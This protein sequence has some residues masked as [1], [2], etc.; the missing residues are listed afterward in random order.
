MSDQPNIILIITDQQRYDT[1]NALGA[2]W[3]HTP[4]LDRLVHE[5]ISFDQC[6]C[7]SAVCVPS[8]ASFFSME[9]PHKVNSFGNGSPWHQCWVEDFQKAGYH[10][11]NV[12]KMHTQPMDGPFGFDQRYVV[13]N[14]DRPPRDHQ[15]HGGFFDDWDRYLLFSGIEKPS[16][17][18]YKANHLD[19]ENGLGAFT[20]P[21]DEHLQPDM[22]VGNMAVQIINQRN[23]TNPLF[24]EIGFPGPHPPYD[25]PKRHLDLYNDVD[26]PV[27]EVTDEE[28]AN[29]PPHHALQRQWCLEG[30]HDAVNWQLKPSKEQ[31]LRLRRHYAANVTT[32][33]EQVGNIIN[34]LEQKDLLDNSVIVFM[35]D[36]GDCTGDHG[37]IQKWTMYDAIT[38]VPAIVWSPGRLPEG[39]Q[40]DALIQHMDLAPMLFELAELDVPDHTGAESALP[41]ANDQSNGRDAVF[42]ELNGRGDY[43][44]MVRTH[45][46]KLVSYLE[47]GNIGELYDLNA[48]PDELHNLWDK[49][50]H[51]EIRQTLLN[52][53]RIW[54]T[55]QSIKE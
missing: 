15:N 40:T 52:R 30:N 27:P 43:L 3:M 7:T 24:L 35:S 4:N 1:I 2:P 42:C 53:I 32:I 47:N 29:Q 37:H 39:K 6:H 44:V 14:K 38:R 22:F 5:G 51:T 18:N 23:A 55:A 8:R 54:H 50:E 21:L 46:W 16:R 25:P 20:W 31:L 45:K 12:G 13:E 48:D 9:Y 36:H 33:D 49:P 10:T 34:A 28:L 19:W 41:V 26:I 17:A 11:I